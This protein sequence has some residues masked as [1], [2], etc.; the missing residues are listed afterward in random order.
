MAKQRAKQIRYSLFGGG[1]KM[2]VR[3]QKMVTP[4]QFDKWRPVSRFVGELSND[5]RRRW[6]EH[7][8]DSRGRKTIYDH[9]DTGAMWDGMGVTLGAG[10]HGERAVVTF[11]G[12]D[13][14]GT[15][16]KDKARWS[17]G[18]VEESIL[19]P[20]DPQWRACVSAAVRQLAKV[21]TGGM[22]GEWTVKIPGG[23]RRLI[24]QID[25]VFGD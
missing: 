14:K 4:E 19:M 2:E 17:S 25:D 9:K 24:S 7:R 21:T 18:H 3:V 1:L 12:R 10:K 5:I 6:T 8:R 13:S 15:Q 11:R 23:D 20:S 22:E 16:N